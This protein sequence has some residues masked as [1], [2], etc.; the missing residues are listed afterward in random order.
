MKDVIKYIII[1]FISSTI[2]FF[3]GWYDHEEYSN[4]PLIVNERTTKVD[5]QLCD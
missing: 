2:G 3:Y 5:K 1:I 4:K